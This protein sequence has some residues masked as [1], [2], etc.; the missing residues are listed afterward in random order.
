MGVS[1]SQY[2]HTIDIFNSSCAAYSGAK[3]HIASSIN[4]ID[5]YCSDNSDYTRDMRIVLYYIIIYYIVNFFEILS[6]CTLYSPK[7]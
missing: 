6:L 1:L 5:R 7:G 2:R 3:H 4:D